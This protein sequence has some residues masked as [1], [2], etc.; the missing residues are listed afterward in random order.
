MHESL[1][2]HRQ[3]RRDSLFERPTF[4]TSAPAAADPGIL[5]RVN[6]GGK[7]RSLIASS[8]FTARRQ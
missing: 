8:G 5:A 4:G 6:L 3:I 7:S 1:S 2:S